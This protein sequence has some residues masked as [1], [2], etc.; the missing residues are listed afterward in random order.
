MK[1]RQ[2]QVLVALRQVQVFL[3]ENAALV[4]KEGRFDGPG[5]RVEIRV[6][7]TDE[8]LLIARDTRLVVAASTSSQPSENANADA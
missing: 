1:K 4:G 8:E 5:S 3:D 7:P 6:I 2:D